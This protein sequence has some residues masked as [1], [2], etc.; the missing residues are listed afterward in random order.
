LNRYPQIAKVVFFMVLMLIQKEGCTQDENLEEQIR[1]EILEGTHKIL[2]GV[3]KLEALLDL[4][5]YYTQKNSR[6]AARYAKQAVILADDIFI[7]ESNQLKP[8]AS[9]ILPGSYIQLGKA[10]Y[11]SSKFF[12]SK[13][14]FERAKQLSTTISFVEGVSSAELYLT[15]IDSLTQTGQ[16]LKKGF[17]S[18]SFQSLELD[19]KI[20][21]ATL[22]WNINQKISSAEAHV[23][24]YEYDQAISDYN[25]AIDLLKSKG[26]QEQTAILNAKIQ[27]INNLYNIDHEVAENYQD[28]IAEQQRIAKEI[29]GDTVIEDSQVKVVM[30]PD[31]ITSTPEVNLDNLFK[32]S[33]SLNTIANAFLKN[34]DYDQAERYR[35]LSL[36]VEDEIK[37]REDTE[38]QLILLRQQ[39]QLSDFDLQAKK[40]EIER[41]QKTKQNIIIGTGLLF[42]LALAVLSLY[43]TK[44]RDH[45]KLSKAYQILE[46]TKAKLTD[47]ERNISK[48]LRQQVS[49]DIAKELMSGGSFLTTKKSFVC[50][51]FLD[52]RGFTPW[53]EKKKPEEIIEYQ[54]NIFGFMIDIVNEFN[55][56]INQFL[57]DGFM[58]TFGA[59]KSFN[60][61]CQNAF[62][63]ALKII[64]ILKEK[65]R[66]GEIRNTK[67]GIGLHA[68][69]V[70][71]GNV[72][73]E[74]RKQYSITGNTVII[75]SRIEQL[76]KQFESQLT[77]S[78][79]VYDQLD[80][81]EGDKSLKKI[82]VKGRNK[83]IEI[84]TVM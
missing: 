49:E 82:E 19:E 20:S 17:F 65:I 35:L 38:T 29:T 84:L 78:K 52:I 8:G 48:L 71:T 77:I 24:K 1:I 4:S 31:S 80:S 14:A 13:E 50:I 46:E 53:A 11:Y 56:N 3:E 10:Y 25:A 23:K 39:K 7:D 63:A 9:N 67:I 33:D 59:P 74:L 30:P 28:A 69:N 43:I 44:Q 68:G 40:M 70:V 12:D 72:G 34:K 18:R 42:A 41:Q 26:D 73:T 60:N 6:K 2:N 36:Q 51:M 54:N 32:K 83:P 62:N 55:G 21:S 47:A 61:D 75:A 16:E 58:A 5:N 37:K 64:K 57:G 27:E 15:K 22:D 81:Y 66:N 45:K 76:N 79:D